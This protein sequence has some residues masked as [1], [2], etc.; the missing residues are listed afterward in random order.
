[1]YVR[2]GKKIQKIKGKAR[3]A[4]GQA[5]KRMEIPLGLCIE[6]VKAN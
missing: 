2:K 5:R 6:V 1:M 4:W 3:Q